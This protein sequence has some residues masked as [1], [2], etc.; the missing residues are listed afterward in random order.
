MMLPKSVEALLQTRAFAELENQAADYLAQYREQPG[1]DQQTAWRE[2]IVA[3]ADSDVGL[4]AWIEELPDSAVAH[5]ALGLRLTREARAARGTRTAD[6][7]SAEQWERVNAGYDAARDHLLRALELGAPAGMALT[8]LMEREQIQGS[9]TAAERYFSRLLTEDPQWFD[10]WL[11]IQSVREPRWGGNLADMEALLE[12]ADG[13]L[14][15]ATQRQR[16]RS[17]H[18]WW[19]G[20]YLY[21]WESDY[22]QALRALDEALALAVMPKGVGEIQEYRAY[23]LKELER[24][25]AALSAWEAAVAADPDSAEYRFRIGVTLDE[26]GRLPEALPHVERGAELGGEYGYWCARFLGISWWE[27]QGGVP[28]DAERAL[29][30]YARALALADQAERRADMACAAASIHAAENAPQVAEPLYRQACMEG[31]AEAPRRLAALL[32]ERDGDDQHEEVVRLYRLA[33]ERGQAAAATELLEYLQR[34]G[35]QNAELLSEARQRAA[36]SGDGKAVRAM[37]RD[38]WERGRT[39]DA[40]LWLAQGAL[41]STDC[42]YALGRGF[43]E[44]WFGRVDHQQAYEAL[45]ALLESYFHADASLSYCVSL[46]EISKQ[47]WASMKHLNREIERLLTWQREGTIEVDQRFSEE[48]RTLRSQ[49]PRGWIGWRLRK[50]FGRLPTL[51]RQSE[52]PQFWG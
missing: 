25:E 33:V 34:S 6:Q 42:A 17:V 43:A 35:T 26:A 24:P 48:L 10:G 29:H 11:A 14:E 4:D 32:A 23:V 19:R 7:V 2:F 30:W 13:V 47:D 22:P 5:L 16:L 44:G 46:H 37:A 31:S 20:S 8:C 3:C 51:R 1:V 18:G 50:L 40:L 15:S 45:N 12:Q 38:C 49:V 36:E 21:H 9:R 39:T 52:I 27:G 41:H 28:R